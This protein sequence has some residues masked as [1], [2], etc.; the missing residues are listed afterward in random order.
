M[1]IFH[2]HSVAREE[3]PESNTCVA[4]ARIRRQLCERHDF[5]GP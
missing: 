5:E 1:S 3:A 4:P 2:E